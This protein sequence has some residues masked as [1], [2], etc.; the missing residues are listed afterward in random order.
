MSTSYFLLIVLCVLA[1]IVLM[2]NIG[3][4]QKKENVTLKWICT[5]LFAFSMMRYLTLIVYG[6][7][8]TLG[9]LEI[10]RYFYL[11]TSI[12]IT[13]TMA[14]TVWCITPYIREKL[15]YLTYLV[16]FTPWILF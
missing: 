14:S 3:I 16:L 9:Q 5:F 2:V 10:L 7:H 8:P 4:V 13:M 1:L 12:G 15:N 6:D 11:A